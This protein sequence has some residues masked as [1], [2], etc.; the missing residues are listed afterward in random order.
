MITGYARTIDLM[1]S[2]QLARRGRRVPYL[3]LTSNQNSLDLV[4][5]QLFPPAVVKLSRADAGVICNR[6]GI[7]EC[8]AILQIRRDTRGSEAVV[9]NLRLDA[10]CAGPSADHGVSVSLGQR[11]TGEIPCAPPDR[12]KQK[13][14]GVARKP[15]AVQIGHKGFL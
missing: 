4:E 9:P 11:R 12:A 2:Y 7:F 13:S 3:S 10:S 1:R 8:A 14:L 15:S 6:G 5:A